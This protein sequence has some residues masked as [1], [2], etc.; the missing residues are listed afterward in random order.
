[1]AI[2]D[3]L[4]NKTAKEKAQ[5]KSQE[6]AKLNIKGKFKEKDIE[7]E[8]LSL[9]AI[10]VNGQHGVQIMA[11]AWKDGKQLGFIDGTVDIERFRIFNP[12]ILVDDPNGDIIKEYTDKITN[13]VKIRKLKEDPIEA[14]RQSLVHTIGLVGKEDTQIVKG[15]VGTTTDTF[16]PDAGNPG[17]SS[18]DGTIDIRDAGS[19]SAARTAKD[20]THL[21]YN[22][23]TSLYVVSLTAG[24]SKWY[25]NRAVINF[26]TA[27][28]PTDNVISSAVISLYAIAV[29]SDADSYRIVQNTISSNTA[30]ATADFDLFNSTALATDKESTSIT[31]S[32]YNNWALN[33]T[34]I[35]I[36]Q[37]DGV[38]HF[39]VRSAE[40]CDNTAPT[41]GNSYFGCSSA[42]EDGT[43]RD[44][45]LVVTHAAAGSSSESPSQSP[46]SSASPSLSPSSS[47]SPSQSPSSSNSPSNSP[48]ESSSNSPSQSPSSS[49]SPSNSPSVSSSPS[50]SPSQSGSPSSSNSPSA[51]SSNSPSLSPSSSASPS[52]SSSQSPSSSN[53]PSE[54][55][56]LSPSS[57][58]SPSASPSSSN[59]P[60]NSPSQSPSSSESPSASSSNSPS[61]SPS[62]SSSPSQSPSSS[63]SPS[64]SSSVSP[65]PSPQVWTRVDRHTTTWTRISRHST[66][67]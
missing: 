28:I 3:L 61:L 5:T 18:V 52:E 53:S 27:S 37:K 24:G 44:P 55:P 9:E 22:G 58:A 41:G 36:I 1:M 51:S 31:T 56:S 50:S 35:G 10:E 8:I 14:I 54:S 6:I 38:S 30:Y 12:P 40:E 48:S 19:F 32:A 62:S 25:I 60:S 21:D 15:K 17:S 4:E 23:E 64:S 34:G 47:D 7:V 46:S 43:S 57:S 39:G 11:R 66:S 45:K 59:S 67:T 16:Y 49:N 33:S 29:G 2:K 26:N 63:N 20:G 13:E 42:D 65:S